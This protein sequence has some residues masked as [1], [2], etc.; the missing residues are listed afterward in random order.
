MPPLYRNIIRIRPTQ[1]EMPLGTR[2]KRRD[3]RCR[4]SRRGL[5]GRAGE[6]AAAVVFI[7]DVQQDLPPASSTRPYTRSASFTTR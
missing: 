3:R 5:R 2:L 6:A 4:C 1:V 7:F